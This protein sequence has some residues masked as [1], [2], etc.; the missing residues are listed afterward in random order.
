MYLLEVRDDAAG[1]L[2]SAARNWAVQREPADLRIYARAAQR[3]HASADA[4][5]IARWLRATGYQDR[6][7]CALTACGAREEAP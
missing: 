2:E 4:A 5:V 1:A 6:T 7:L 3:A